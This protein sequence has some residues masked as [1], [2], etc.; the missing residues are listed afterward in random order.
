MNYFGHA[1]V[2]SWT[3]H[4]P[5]IVLGAMLPDFASMC[6]ARVDDASGDPDVAAGIDL[7]HRTDSVFHQLPIVTGLMRELDAILEAGGCARG[8]RRGTAHIG[9]ELLLD[10]V[11]VADAAYRAAYERALAHDAQLGWRDDGAVRYATLVSRLRRYGAPDDLRDPAAVTERLARVLG[12]RPRLAP[13]ADDLRV[14]ERSLA[15]HQPRV[16]AATPAV[17]HAL[18]G[19]LS[20]IPPA[21]PPGGLGVIR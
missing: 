4:A 19:H 6:S 14:I 10:G 9:V 8:P 17:L 7:H 16:I 20:P 3:H 11:L 2:A 18:R 15:A 12:S 21:S 13:T 5:S 1:A